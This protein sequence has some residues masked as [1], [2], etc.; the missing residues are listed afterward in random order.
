MVGDTINVFIETI[1]NT[2]VGEREII[3][4]NIKII[5]I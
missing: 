5:I 4:D 3:T 2:D 1:F